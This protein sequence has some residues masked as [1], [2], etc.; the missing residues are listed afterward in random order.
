MTGFSEDPQAPY[1]AP[2]DSKAFLHWAEQQEGR[3]EF[4]NGRIVCLTPNTK[5][6][7]RILTDFA[8][9][10][11]R[12]LDPDK[13]DVLP[14]C[15]AVEIC[16]DI[17]CPDVVVERR[18]TDGSEVSTSTPNVLVEVLSLSSLYR[19]KFE[20]LAEY[21][22]LASLECYIVA[23]QDEPIVWVWQRDAAT[24]AFPKIPNEIGDRDGTIEISALELSLPLSEL[25]RAIL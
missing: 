18:S 4:K 19:D 21:T 2:R 23:S 17:R 13:W 25:F 20:K 7:S 22:S 9:T 6:H 24:R 3:F 5:R 8:M 14:A 11:R 16:D 1:G 12:Q 10:L 15:F